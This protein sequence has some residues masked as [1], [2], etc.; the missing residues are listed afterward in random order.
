M[1]SSTNIK[2]I[3]CFTASCI[4]RSKLFR[5]VTELLFTSSLSYVV[6]PYLAVCW[7]YRNP[8]NLIIVLNLFRTILLC[9]MTRILGKFCFDSQGI[10]FYF[11]VGF[12]C[13]ALIDNYN[14][15]QQSWWYNMAPCCFT[16]IVFLNRTIN[17]QYHKVFN[18][19]RPSW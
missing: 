1:N 4:M 8:N 9:I 13:K 6:L 3:L 10:Y 7:P 16:C 18:K 2:N 12:S 11:R 14:P 15:D 17:L 19:C 5:I